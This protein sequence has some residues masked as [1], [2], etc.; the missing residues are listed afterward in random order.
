MDFRNFSLPLM[1]TVAVLVTVPVAL[2]AQLTQIETA[3]QLQLNTI[4]TAVPF[5]MI[6][7]D[8]RS[9]ALGD[10]GVALTPDGSAMAWN[11]ARMAFTDQ[12]FEAHMGYAPWLRQLV[13]DMSLAY[14]SGTRKLN[15]RQAVGM[16]LR[17]FSLGNITFTDVNGTAIR[18]FSPNEFSLDFGFSQKFGDKF[19]GGFTARYI[20]SNLTGG[21]NI[22]GADSRPGRSVAV[23]VGV[24]HSN[25]NVKFGD[26]DGRMN[27][28]ICISNV[29]AKMSYTET[30]ERDFIPTNLKTGVAAT[31]FLDDYNNL[32]FTMDANK[33]LVPTAPA[34]GEGDDDDIIVSGY[35]PNV[36][37]ATGILQSF[38]DA[39]GIVERQGDGTYTIE[40]GSILREELR[41]VN[42]GG[43][44]EY[45]Y[46]G[47]F[48]VRGG[49]FYEH[50]TKGNRQFITLGAGIK[51]TVL[52]IDLSYLIA[53]TQQ[54]PLANTLRFSL[55]LAFDDVIGGGDDEDPSNF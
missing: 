16:A 38:Y 17:Y 15:K 29:G 6:A 39:P 28:G 4:T 43:G 46:N 13:D 53:T 21:T 47:V 50:F 51:Y 24:L 45:D 32:T 34:Y 11:P 10:A 49:Y 30:A 41:E 54:N 42:L 26:R 25:D 40:P 1:L 2:Q 9:G 37:V 35:D 31:V 18:D 44:I 22:L 33:L 36:G 27:W 8:S 5:L 7:P 3:E 12:T 55:R 23:D 19:S 20:H 14:L 52:D 48:A